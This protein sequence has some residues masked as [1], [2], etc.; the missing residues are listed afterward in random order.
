MGN[1]FVSCIMDGNYIYFNIYFRH[2]LTTV[3]VYS[4]G[5]IRCIFEVELVLLMS[6]VKFLQGK[7]DYI[8][9]WI[10]Y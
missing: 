2:Q 4:V 7:A 8:L 6:Y 1:F 9:D 3:L 5:I 10:I